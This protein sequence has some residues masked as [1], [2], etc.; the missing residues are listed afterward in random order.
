MSPSHS[1]GRSVSG[2]E[3]DHRSG[4]SPTQITAAEAA[5]TRTAALPGMGFLASKTGEEAGSATSAAQPMALRT[6]GRHGTAG[7]NASRA[8]APNSQAR[9]VV[10]KYAQ[11]GSWAVIHSE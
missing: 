10:T 8:P 3:C 11:D 2:R 1:A 9:A 6:A 5:T 4:G 7:A